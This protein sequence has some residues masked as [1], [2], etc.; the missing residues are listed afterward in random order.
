[1]HNLIFGFEM[2]V[3][4]LIVV[5]TSLLLL[6]LILIGFSKLFYK[7]ES[8]QRRKDIDDKTKQT[9]GSAVETR[10]PATLET[11]TA[12]GESTQLTVRP[13]IIAAAMGALLFARDTKQNPLLTRNIPGPSTN[14]WAQTGRSRALSIRQDFALIRKGK[15]R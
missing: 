14:I 2:M 4:G 11:F 3:M 9:S 10:S 12:T 15:R 6:A 7:P 13:E 1:M 5:F 8:A